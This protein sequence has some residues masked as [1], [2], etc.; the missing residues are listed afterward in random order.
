MVRA[1]PLTICSCSASG[2]IGHAH[3]PSHA[4]T[5]GRTRAL[6]CHGVTTASQTR[7]LAS[8]SASQGYGGTTMVLSLERTRCITPSYLRLR[9]ALG[10]SSPRKRCNIRRV[11]LV[12]MSSHD[13]HEDSEVEDRSV[14]DRVSRQPLSVPRRAARGRTCS[15][16]QA[17]RHLGHGPLRRSPGLSYGL[18][19]VLFLRRVR[20]SDFRK[21][22]PWRPPSL[23]LEADPPL[24]T[25][26]R[27]VLTR[28]CSAA[29]MKK[30]WTT[31]EHNPWSSSRGTS[32][33]ITDLAGVYALK[34][35]PN[36][37]GLDADG[38]EHLLP[39]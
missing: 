23:I 1:V 15:L 28:I 30:L 25:R 39:Y 21:G 20:L 4:N 26:T 14:R 7:T 3:G 18:G 32:D 34:V 36:A 2:S 10:A 6:P 8:T 38:R 19:D 5:R 11:F 17:V 16:A 35:F 12:G 29:A 33:E 9:S 24:H 13:A 27:V 37:A 31:F 22:T